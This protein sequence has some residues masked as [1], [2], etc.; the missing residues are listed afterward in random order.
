MKYPDGTA[1]NYIPV[2]TGQ[3]VSVSIDDLD[4]FN[5]AM[6]R[7]LLTAMQNIQRDTKPQEAEPCGCG[8]RHFTCALCGEEFVS[9]PEFT[10]EQRLEEMRSHFGDVPE[11]EIRSVCEDCFLKIHPERN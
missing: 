4:A 1:T 7:A 8:G 6:N 9:D 10:E 11:E 3:I 5:A 2:L